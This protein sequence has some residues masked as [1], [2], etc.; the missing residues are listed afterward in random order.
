MRLAELS[1]GD[2]LNQKGEP[3]AR[4]AVR[5]K[6]ALG[7]SIAGR[8]ACSAALFVGSTPASTT[9]V[10]NAG[11]IASGS[12]HSDR[13]TGWP[14]VAP[15]SSTARISAATRAIAAVSSARSAQSGP[16]TVRTT[17]LPRERSM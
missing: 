4:L 8:S 7:H 12:R 14:A 16:R 10:H 5:A 15:A 1:G 2:G 3:A 9:N 17:W 11:H 6:A 13:A